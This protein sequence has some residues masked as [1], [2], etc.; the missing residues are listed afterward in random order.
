MKRWMRGN[1]AVLASNLGRAAMHPRSVLR[2]RS[3]KAAAVTI[4]AGSVIF[5]TPA[6]RDR[7]RDQRLWS[8]LTTKAWV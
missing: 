3:F 7:D 8:G 4:I 5:S 6:P 1:P 2:Y